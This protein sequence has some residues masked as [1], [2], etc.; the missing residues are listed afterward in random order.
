MY[1]KKIPAGLVTIALIV[2]LL[3]GVLLA[4]TA[5]GYAPPA[6]PLDEDFSEGL[7]GDWNNHFYWTSS[8]S[9]NAGGTSPEADLNWYN[10]SSTLQY[11]ES[12]PVDTTGASG[13][14]LE[15]KSYI[16]DSDGGYDCEVWVTADGI[17]WSDVTPWSNPIGG[18]VGP[19]T[20]SLDISPYIG[21][22]TQAAFDFLG[23]STD[24]NDWYIDDVK[25]CKSYTVGGE[26]YPVDTAAVLAPWI[27]AVI[28]IVPGGL[29]LARRR[30]TH[31]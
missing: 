4:G 3:T 13:L 27:L 9:G 21:S 8:D 24:I 23:S 19:G 31:R 20:Y 18:D 1:N 25:I 28:V 7:P 17:D 10:I 5:A 16:D 15:F 22:A 2:A 29:Y 14:T 6:C 12:P 11:L 26:A 30:F